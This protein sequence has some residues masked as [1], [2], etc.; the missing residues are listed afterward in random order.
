MCFDDND[1]EF[2]PEDYD[3]NEVDLDFEG[4]D[5]PEDCFYDGET[6]TRE[7]MIQEMNDEEWEHDL[8]EDSTDTEVKEEYGRYYDEKYDDAEYL[9][10]PNGRDLDAENED[11]PLG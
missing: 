11:G 9:L 1:F 3:D 4:D 6:P 8:T 2:D 5:N 7:E 10:F